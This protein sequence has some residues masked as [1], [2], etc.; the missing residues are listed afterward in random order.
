MEYVTLE[1]DSFEAYRYQEKSGVAKEV[2]GFLKK[3]FK[4]KKKALSE[5]LLTDAG[6]IADDI[7]STADLGRR[8]S[9]KINLDLTEVFSEPG[10]DDDDPDEISDTA[11]FESRKVKTVPINGTKN[12]G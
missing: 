12:V 11:E 3:L 6:D 9:A 4:P 2:V 7:P 1:T 10:A 8:G 5:E